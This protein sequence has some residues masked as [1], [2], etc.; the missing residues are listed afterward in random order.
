[1]RH[2]QVVQT[3]A[4]ACHT[5]LCAPLIVQHAMCFP[6]RAMNAMQG[7]RQGHGNLPQNL[8]YGPS[9][10]VALHAV[11]RLNQQHLKAQLAGGCSLAHREERVQQACGHVHEKG[12][13]A[14][15]AWPC[16]H[17]RLKPRVHSAQRK[18][19]QQA[20]GCTQDAP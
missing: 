18:C 17:G 14:M 10:T 15:F 13:R 3:H 4:F 9:R 7:Q 16:K 11:T 1:M 19:S 5:S 20:A 6:I 2:L 12:V 8:Q